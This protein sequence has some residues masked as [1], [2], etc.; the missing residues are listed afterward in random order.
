LM[1]LGVMA[2]HLNGQRLVHHHATTSLQCLASE[3]S[4]QHSIYIT[5]ILKLRGTNDES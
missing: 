3:V 2:H 1:T 5:H 4:A